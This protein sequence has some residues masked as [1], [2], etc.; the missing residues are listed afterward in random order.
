MKALLLYAKIALRNVWRNKRRS[1]LTI[2]A[3]SFGL[4]CLVLFQALKVGLH[5]EMVKST[6]NLETGS[7]QIHASGYEANLTA[8]RPIP[9]IDRVISLLKKENS[10]F[11]RRLK[12]PALLS[13]GE[14]SSSVLLSG[15]DTAREPRVTFIKNQIVKGRYLAGK[16]SIL[17]G[18]DMARDLGAD[19]GDTVTLTAQN[20]SGNSITANFTIGGLYKTE[21]ASFDRSHVY[22]SLPDAQSFLKAPGDVTE[23]AL[24]NKTLSEKE[25]VSRLK[26][27]L[28]EKTFQIRTWEEIAPDVRQIIE[29]NDATMYLLVL[30]V[31]AIVALGITNTMTMVIYERFHELGILSS[32]GTSPSGILAMIVFE[33]LFLGIIA[34]LAGSAV[35]FL[36]CAYL[37]RYGIDLTYFTSANQYLA[38]SHVL[39]AYLSS[40]D[41]LMA[42]T[43]TLLTALLAGIYPAWKAARLKPVEAIRHI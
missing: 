41:L 32:I 27:A 25:L 26:K 21:L 7:V 31:F 34:S 35:S 23:I 29:L 3:I 15:V 24:I 18:Q 43:V 38:S 36:A 11:S 4:F 40:F 33:S 9:D 8:L 22:L 20:L 39:K 37:K 5:R 6:V 17:I 2:L 1:L 12:S 28:P 10:T 30:I 16:E 19:I 42:N 14:K 13:V